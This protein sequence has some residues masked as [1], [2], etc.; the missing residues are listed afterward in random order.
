MLSLLKDC[1]RNV[2]VE[3]EVANGD[4][5]VMI[6]GEL[7]ADNSYGFACRKETTICRDLDV[8]ILRV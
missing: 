1:S 5:D 4:C 6:V 7:R 2:F 8:A 3:Y